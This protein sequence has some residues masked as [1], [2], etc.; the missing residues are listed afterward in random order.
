MLIHN[1]C[2]E[3]VHAMYRGATREVDVD[4][5]VADG[6]IYQQKDGRRA[7]VLSN[8]DGTSSAVILDGPLTDGLVTVLESVPDTSL[9]DRVADGF[10]TATEDL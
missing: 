5:V 1:D 2:N 8:E 10:W 7:Y 6:D 3:P 4:R 9:A